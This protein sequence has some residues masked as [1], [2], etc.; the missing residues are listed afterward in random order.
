MVSKMLDYKESPCESDDQYGLGKYSNLANTL[1]S[2][3]EEISN[4]KVESCRYRRNKER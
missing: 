3:K 1:R 4:F 2:L